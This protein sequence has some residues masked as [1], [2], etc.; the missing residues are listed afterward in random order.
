[1][2]NRS[3]A[4]LI[5]AVLVLVLLVVAWTQ[6]VYTNDAGHIVV[7]QAPVSGT[8][9]VKTAPG[10]YM[11]A[12]SGVQAYAKQDNFDFEKRGN[13]DHSI[14]VQFNDGGKAKVSGNVQW[15]MPQDESHVVALHSLYRSQDGVDANLVRNAINRALTLTAPL[16][17]STES[18]AARRSEFLNDFADQLLN[19]IYQTSSH[20]EQVAD[21]V[22]GEKKMARVFNIQRDKDGQPV[23]SEES[24]FKKYGIT[25]QIPSID[26]FYYEQSVEAQIQQQRSNIMAIQTAQAEAKKAEQ[27]KLTAAANGEA[28]AMAAKWGQEVAKAREVT[29]AE[30]DLAVATIAA[31]REAEVQRIA[32]ERDASV[33]KVA[34][35]RDKM[36]AETAAQ[37]N[38]D[39]ATLSAQQAEQYRIEQ[40]KMGEGESARRKAVLAADGALQAKLD[41][42]VKSQSVWAQALASTRASLVPTIQSGTTQPGQS[43]AALDFMSLMTMKAAKDLALDMT[44]SAQQKAAQ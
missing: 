28:E 35:E 22:T 2:G 34:A 13:D 18:Y 36:V 4:A 25:I 44:I 7:F 12:G 15:E 27:T 16:M 29:K 39:V 9:S 32:A 21:P 8:L 14:L 11:R 33:A 24:P 31:K 6:S 42:W 41:A 26:G 40:T 19:G 43:N 1:M 17:S 3:I 10:T 23:R 37:R 20:D 30:Q 5:G 38:L